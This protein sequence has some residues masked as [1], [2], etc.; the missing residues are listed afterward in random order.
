MLI[1]CHVVFL[2]V[3]GKTGEPWYWLMNALAKVSNTPEVKNESPA[4]CW[5]SVTGVCAPVVVYGG[6]EDV[7][8]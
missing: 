2:L 1:Y 7:N 6:C 8:M 5:E 3:T 4:V